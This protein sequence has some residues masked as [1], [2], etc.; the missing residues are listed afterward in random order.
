[1]QFHMILLSDSVFESVS[2]SVAEL[3]LL[4]AFHVCLN[5]DSVFLIYVKNN[6]VL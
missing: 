3:G 4:S 5:A 6:G 2:A 1:V